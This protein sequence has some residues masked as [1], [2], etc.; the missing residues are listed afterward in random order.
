MRIKALELTGR[1]WAGVPASPADRPPGPGATSPGVRRSVP[2]TITGGRQ[3]NAEPLGGLDEEGGGVVKIDDDHMFHGAA[4]TQV[5][6]DPHF[7]AINAIKLDGVVAENSFRINDDIGIHLKYCST[8]PVGKWREYRFTFTKDHL[9]LLTNLAGATGRVFVALVCVTA[10]EICC[11]GYDELHDLLNR[12]RE[13]KGADEA[14]YVVP[15][16]LTQHGSF[17]VYVNQPGAKGK[18]IGKA[19]T[20]P[21]SA[22]PKRLFE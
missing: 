8:K 9:D 4:L 20:V 18:I 19:I 15:V 3:L 10:R 16:T 7:T 21:R 17:H 14:Q 22:F 5:A 12:R 11:L 13:A 2:G 1:R 6:E